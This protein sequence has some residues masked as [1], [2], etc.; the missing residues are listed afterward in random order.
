VL[1]YVKYYGILTLSSDSRALG[2]T[3]LPYNMNVG[4]IAF[5][6]TP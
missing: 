6:K 1:T 2:I 5:Q 3:I 4:A